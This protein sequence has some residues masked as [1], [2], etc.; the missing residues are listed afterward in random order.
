MSSSN[1]QNINNGDSASICKDTQTQLKIL[2]VDDDKSSGE[3]L[4]DIVIYRG[5]TVT[6]LDEGMKFVNR[7]NEEKFDLIFMDYHTNDLY[8]LDEELGKESDDNESHD[9]HEKYVSRRKIDLMGAS[10]SSE[11]SGDELDESETVTEITGTYVA[12][13]ARECYGL[14]APIFAYT[15][16]NSAEALKDFQEAKFK[17]V[18]VKPVEP[19]LINGFFDVIEKE[20]ELTS[21]STSANAKLRRLSVKSKNFIFFRKRRSRI[22]KTG[23]K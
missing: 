12:N 9:S 3:S 11:S 14:D 13:L 2:I 18:F 22:S 16:D 10:D 4:R 5:H 17:G 21:M 19:F 23:I 20:K 15:G 6:L 7:M 1:V 8:D